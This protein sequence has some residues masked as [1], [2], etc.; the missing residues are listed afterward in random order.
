MTRL[1]TGSFFSYS[2][3]RTELCPSAQKMLTLNRKRKAF[4]LKPKIVSFKEAQRDKL[5]R[6]GGGLLFCCNFEGVSVEFV[7][8][9]NLKCVVLRTS[10][11]T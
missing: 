11:G 6:G 7:V 3:L 2:L 9:R 8:P 10:P 1:Q 4:E 5:G